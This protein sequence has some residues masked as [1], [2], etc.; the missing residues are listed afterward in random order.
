MMLRKGYRLPFQLFGI[1]VY[2]D[3]TFLVILP[4]LAWMIGS[5]L[6][7]YVRLLRLGVD[8]AALQQGALPYVLGLIAAL[9]LFCS[10]LVHE[11]GHSIV[12][13]RYGVEAKRITLWILGGVA[14]LEEMPR[15][16]GAE[17][18]VAIAGPFTSFA[19]AALCWVI[20]AS[21]PQDAASARFI[22]GYLAFTNVALGTFNL[23]PALPLDG[24]RVLRSLLALRMPHLRATQLAASVSQVLA[25]LLGLVGFLSLNIFL[26][27]V[28]FFVYMAGSSEAQ[29]TLVAEMLEGIGVEYLMTRD[30]QTV[31]PQMRVS[32]LVDKML[33]ER[34]LGY[35]VLDDAGG[36]VGMVTLGG[37]QGADPNATVEQVMSRRIVTIQQNRSALEAFQ[38]M[39]RNNFERLVVVNPWGQMVGIISKTDLVRAVQVR[40]VGLALHPE[41]SAS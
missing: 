40:I 8:P 22:F 33:R 20:L 28:A 21:F 29:T 14:Q 4:L 10:V 3:S 27:L 34:H 2:L 1:P 41:P 31:H 15:Q 17:A 12:A 26:V 37:I 38:T 18:V 36:L 30:V 24:G 23:L 35:P 19:V 7:L 11:L 5:R 39:S 13:R 6:D 25:V 32:D 16:R 9:G